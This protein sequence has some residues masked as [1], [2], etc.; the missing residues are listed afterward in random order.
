MALSDH[1][2]W[3]TLY[4]F[5][6]GRAEFALIGLEQVLEPAEVVELQEVIDDGKALAQAQMNRLRVRAG[7]QARPTTRPEAQRIDYQ[8]DPLFGALFTSLKT[9]TEKL[10]ATHEVHI[11]S[12][13]LITRHYPNGAVSI[14]AQQFEIQ[15]AAGKNLLAELDEE[16][17]QALVSKLG[18]GLYIDELRPLM[19]AYE[20]A[21]RI[22]APRTVTA[23][24]ITTGQNAVQEALCRVIHRILGRF[25]APD[26]APARARLLK[27]IDDQNTRIAA[28]YRD[29]LKLRDVDP[30]TGDEIDT[31]DENSAENPATNASGPVA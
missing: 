26:Q 29:R 12:K 8:I 22:T 11:A 3:T 2:T 20:A 15:L 24:D 4:P 25:D 28:Y 10:P 27:P 17:L 18:L 19:V 13:D 31:P 1:R 5:P 14:T 23:D 16:R 30:K 9:P 7:E 21:L 6:P